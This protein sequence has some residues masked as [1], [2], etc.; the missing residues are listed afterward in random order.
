LRS[1]TVAFGI[2]KGRP[3]PFAEIQTTLNGP[4]TNRAN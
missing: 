4:G 3:A 2:T 1:Q